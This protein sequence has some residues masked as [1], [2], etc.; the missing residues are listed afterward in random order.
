M[1]TNMMYTNVCVRRKKKLKIHTAASWT[2][3]L[4]ALDVNG[5]SFFMAMGVIFLAFL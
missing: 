1:K 2:D 5:L 4:T 3:S